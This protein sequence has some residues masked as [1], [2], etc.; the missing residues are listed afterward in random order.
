MDAH[1]A[2]EVAE[3]NVSPCLTTRHSHSKCGIREGFFHHTDEFDDILGHKGNEAASRKI[4]QIGNRCS[5]AYMCKISWFL[6][7]L[8]QYLK[9]ILKY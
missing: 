5:K 6:K 3:E 8:L 1:A 2:S 4:L 7:N 9:N